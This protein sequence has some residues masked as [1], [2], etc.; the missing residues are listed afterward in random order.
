MDLLHLHTTSQALRFSLGPFQLAAPKLCNSLP[1]SLRSLNSVDSFKKQLETHLFKQAFSS[2]VVYHVLICVFFFCIPLCIL[3][4]I[5]LYFIYLNVMHFV[6][7]VYERCYI[8]TLYLF[9][10]LFD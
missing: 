10:L 9:M 7:G 5:Y 4:V 6:T 8:N 3:S 2:H 1:T